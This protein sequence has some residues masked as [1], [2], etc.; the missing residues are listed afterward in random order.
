MRLTALLNQIISALFILCYCYQFFYMIVV[1]IHR[2]R[3]EHVTHLHRFAVLC[4]ARNEED[5]I[6]QLIRSIQQ[7]DY[8]SEL[9]DIYIVADNCT[10]RTAQVAR[11]AGAYVL[12]RFNQKERGKGYALDFLFSHIFSSRGKEAYDAYVIFDAD[13]LLKQ[14]Y[15]QHMNA[16]LCDGHKIV[17]SC[18]NT[19]NYGE[20]WLSAAYGLWFLRESKFLNEAR[21]LL[22][23]SSV[24]AGTGFMVHR[25]II[26]ENGG[27]KYHL[28][29]E[30]TEFTVDQIL[31]GNRVAYCAKAVFY[32]EQP[33]NFR[34]SVQQRM[35]WSKGYFQV[36]GKYRSRLMDG[37]FS[38][39]DI[40]M[41]N[42]PA[43]FLTLIGLGVNLSSLLISL[44]GPPI[45]VLHSWDFLVQFVLGSYLSLLLTG[46]VTLISMW[47]EILAPA[48][49]KILY[50][51]LFPIFIFTYLPISVA[52][53]FCKVEWVGIK[54]H[55]ATQVLESK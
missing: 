51:P 38:S 36:L 14:D 23:T 15:L 2:P 19:K 43:M 18:R 20:N 26:L 29:S 42:L 11:N 10:D 35:R 31:K 32:D 13:N 50:F 39:Y 46:G 17:T 41:T 54:H 22:R 28:L 9:V 12:E 24:V 34:Q 52:S 16:M 45:Y 6:E 4:S 33:T 55:V 53:L 3:R 25:D 21:M 27:W 7:Q 8:P 37:G 48:W 44:F 49:K 40:V 1:L 47:K 5:V 30:D